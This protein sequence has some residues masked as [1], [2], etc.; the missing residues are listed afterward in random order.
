M[1]LP[2]RLIWAEHDPFFPLAV[3]QRLRHT[4]PGAEPAVHVVP[5]AG[6]FVP[7]DRPED[8]TRLI[9]EFLT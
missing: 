8:V 2:V 6:H 4:L 3:A 9:A 7:E 5:G 1:R